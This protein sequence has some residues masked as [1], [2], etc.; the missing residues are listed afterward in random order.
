MSEGDFLRGDWPAPANIR[1]LFTPRVLAARTGL[2]G[3]DAADFNLGLT[4]GDE[5]SA[6]LRRRAW[7]EQEV[8]HAL[9]WIGQ[10]HG[11]RVA[12]LGPGHEL[13]A[14]GPAD[15]VWT[16]APGVPCLM[17]VAD[18]LPVCFAR[19]DGSAVGVAH[20]GWRGLCAGVLEA[21]V[22]AMQRGRAGG[23]EELLAWLGPCI[24][25]QHFEVGP[26]VRAAFVDRDPGA[27]L[28]FRRRGDGKFLCDLPALA[29]RRLAAA[30]VTAAFGGTHCTYADTQQFY[31]HRR[32]THDGTRGGRMAAIVWMAAASSAPG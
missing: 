4:V 24:G 22:A 28:A 25:P 2:A 7:L 32:S 11:T 18:C 30:G 13:S 9:T 20:A 12:R 21:T 14:A 27:G 19:R 8:G 1:T 29:R 16:D 31:S 15:A 26:E 3:A 6:V 10:V 17:L 23:C 5:H